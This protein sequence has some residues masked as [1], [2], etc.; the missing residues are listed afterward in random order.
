MGSSQEILDKLYEKHKADDFS[1]AVANSKQIC[2]DL[3]SLALDYP[4]NRISG[5]SHL[6]GL[7]GLALVLRL[8]G[9]IV[10]AYKQRVNTF[11]DTLRYGHVNGDH[12]RDDYKRSMNSRTKE[13]LMRVNRVNSLL[14]QARTSRVGSL[15]CRY[16][17]PSFPTGIPVDA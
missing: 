5:V 14:S 12:V 17:R 11:Y 4:G 16:K 15:L 1:N 7:W 13:R 10:L 2:D 6:Y 3:N 9:K 8:N